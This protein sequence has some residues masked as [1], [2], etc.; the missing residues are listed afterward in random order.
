MIDHIKNNARNLRRNQTD[1]EKLLW[2]RLRNRNF[3]NLKFRRQHP[4]PPYI[5]DFYCDDLRLIIELDGGQHTEEKDFKRTDFLQ[6][7]GLQILRYWNNDVL[8]NREGILEDIKNKTTPPSPLSSPQGEEKKDRICVAKIATAHGIRGL[9]KLH[10]FVE[11]LDLLKNTLFTSEDKNN[12]LTL[13][14]KNATAKHWL[15]EIEGVKDRNEAEALRGT[16][17]YILKSDMPALN[18][19][20]MY[21]SDMIGLP[22][23]DEQDAKIGKVLALENFGAG[24]LL[25]IQ[26]KGEN[27]FYLP[28]NDDTI[29]HK[30]PTKITVKIPEGLRD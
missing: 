8:K 19:G 5:V 10:V 14:L 29:I 7:N 20:E 11:N 23:V 30:S 13:K 17:L 6:N 28:Y 22:V 26:P 25:E 15:A 21:V 1:A 4:F 12:T 18:D 16:E 27:S 2:S 9:V 24:D 3:L